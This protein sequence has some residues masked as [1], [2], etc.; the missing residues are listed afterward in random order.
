VVNCTKS[1]RFREEFD[2]PR[3]LHSLAPV[4]A[5]LLLLFL[6]ASPA[7]A[8]TAT[9]TGL[10]QDETGAAIA[11]ATAELL[12][13]TTG[14]TRTIL[15]GSD[16]NYSFPALQ[17]AAYTLKVSAPG[18]TSVTVRGVELQV[19][20]IGRRNVTLSVA[21]VSQEITIAGGAPLLQTEEASTG[22]VIE[23]R[24]VTDLPL[25]GRNFKQLAL[26]LPGTIAATKQSTDG[27]TFNIPR[28]Q[29]VSNG[30]LDQT[31]SY[32]IDGIEN[33]H[34]LLT[35]NLLDMSVDAIQEFKIEQNSFNVDSGRGT[36][37]T[38][39]ITRS[40]SNQFHGSVYEFLR[41]DKMDARNF[42]DRAQSGGK[43]SFR[44]N[45]FGGSFG[46]PLVHDRLFFFANGEGRRSLKGQTQ[47]AN[48][49]TPAQLNGDLSGAAPVLDPERIGTGSC[50]AGNEP[51]CYFP[52]NQIPKSRI[53]QF[54]GAANQLWPTPNAPGILPGIND[55]ATLKQ[56][57]NFTQQ[58]FR[59]DWQ[60]GAKDHLFARETTDGSRFT[61]PNI[62]PLQELN[63][64]YHTTNLAAS[65]TRTL[66][67]RVVNEFIFGYNFGN[68]R[69]E[70]PFTSTDVSTQFGLQNLRIP[71]QLYGPPRVTVTGFGTIGPAA[72]EPW[73]EPERIYQWTDNLTVIRGTHTFKFGG[74]F[75]RYGNFSTQP[76]ANRGTTS[77]NGL[78]TGTPVADYLLGYPASASAGQGDTTRDELRF[79][80][81]AFAGDDWKVKPNLTLNLGLRWD[82]ATQ[83]TE[84]NN[85]MAIFDPDLSQFPGDALGAYRQAA[86][87]GAS[88]SILNSQLK[89]FAPRV[90]FA[91]RPLGQDRLVLRGGF[92]TSYALAMQGQDEQFFAVNLPFL[93]LNALVSQGP[94]RFVRTTQLFPA[95][96]A[97][98]PDPNAKFAPLGQGLYTVPQ[99]L[100]FPTSYQWNFAVQTAILRSL[101]LDLAYIGDSNHHGKSRW[102]INQA[103]L[104]PA[105]E[106]ASGVFSSFTP[107][108]A[109]PNLSSIISSPNW[110]NSSY[111][112]LQ[113]KLVKRYSNGVS[114]LASYTWSKAIDDFG[115]SQYEGGAYFYNRRL[116]RSRSGADARQIATF[117]YNWELPFG[118][119]RRY[120][121]GTRGA[122]RQLVDGWAV[123]GVTSFRSGLPLTVFDSANRT[124][125][126]GGTARANR[127]C[128][129][130]LP[131]D[132]RIPTHWFDTSCFTAARPGTLGTAGRRIIDA[133]GIN[134]WDF[135]VFK[136]FLIAEHT[137]LEFR[138]EF[139]NIFNHAQFDIPGM[140]F[141]TP[142]FGVITAARDPRDIQLGLKLVF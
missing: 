115:I 39:V 59:L 105:S 44:M 80:M 138:A 84:K 17:P 100:K 28:A 141:G 34:K 41:N 20:Q 26:L 6:I 56:K 42:F 142:T 67:P 101:S 12:N 66:S 35:I 124:Q 133:P 40:G 77:F 68:Y 3:T 75:M 96:P 71:P 95:P 111:N 50:I 122:L 132:Q 104:P 2:M 25:N 36:T 137:R 92:G 72:Y 9:L 89:T 63:T 49:P 103:T 139:Y 64:T 123:N 52:N 135:S 117:S 31:Y 87:N 116:D 83:P 48:F 14:Q 107:R 22:H 120:L 93:F 24:Q 58:T 110:G 88:R 11:G 127:T 8:Q 85:R 131:T 125:T 37:V 55:V 65:W 99:T 33:F 16:G 73:Y 5:W 102:D 134:N 27:T 91:Y 54:A 46:G 61:R 57:N 121:S 130:N 23:T 108:R 7:A 126:G 70:V 74:E 47:F 13:P 4:V 98:F 97:L 112:A 106:V 128:D 81:T 62:Q 30:V 43:P 82:G 76:F 60:A 32:R 19:D 109:Y 94:T 18:M 86:V 53:S 21:A 78:I 118:P 114:L 38:S 10:V 15:T 136:R 119:G 90:G 113:A 140:T 29:F 51:S 69:L 45:Q 129:G 1:F 79:V